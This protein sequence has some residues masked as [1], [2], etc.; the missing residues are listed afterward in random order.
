[1]PCADNGH[2]PHRALCRCGWLSSGP[3]SGAKNSCDSRG[4]ASML[5]MLN[6]GLGHL[7]VLLQD[8][9]A[10]WLLYA[11]MICWN[12]NCLCPLASFGILQL[13]VAMML[14]PGCPCPMEAVRIRG[15]FWTRSQT[16][17]RRGS[18]FV[19]FPPEGF[20][21]TDLLVSRPHWLENG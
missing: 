11:S 13:A 7:Q 18:A 9:D 2:L 17:A 3:K 8:S 19:Q 14:K 12:W 10:F 20:D 15:P 16:E 1:M 21:S 6:I 4:V 5:N